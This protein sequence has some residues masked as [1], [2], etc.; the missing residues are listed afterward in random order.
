MTNK[1][2]LPL[3][4]IAAMGLAGCDKSSEDHV[5]DANKHVE[6]ADQKQ[7]EGNPQQAADEKT[8]ADKDYAAARDARATEDRHQ[9]PSL[10][11]PGYIKEPEKK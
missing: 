3:L 7:A 4:L 2:T 1:F 8:Q 10:A 9:P 6:T 5:Q 11:S